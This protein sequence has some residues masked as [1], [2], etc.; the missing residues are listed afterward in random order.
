MMRHFT[1]EQLE[2]ILAFMRMGTRVNETLAAGLRENTKAGLAPA[3]QIERARL[4][5]RA[6][7]A[8]APKLQE[9]LDEI[10]PP[11]GEK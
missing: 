4:F 5:R 3:E 8:L 2:G 6:M 1:L 7:D 9:E 11:T 10:L